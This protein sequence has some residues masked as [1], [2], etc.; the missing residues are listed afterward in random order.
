MSRL[1]SEILPQR[2]EVRRTKI[3]KGWC[4]GLV[5]DK[6]RHDPSRGEEL[7]IGPVRVYLFEEEFSEYNS[8]DTPV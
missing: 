5:S 3:E 6:F 2:K 1:Q 4:R 8:P 7:P